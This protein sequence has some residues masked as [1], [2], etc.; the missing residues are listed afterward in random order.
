MRTVYHTFLKERDIAL[1]KFKASESVYVVKII[2]VLDTLC[3]VKIVLDI[4]KNKSN[5]LD[6]VVFNCFIKDLQ[7]LNNSKLEK[8]LKA[9]Y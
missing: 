3:I 9:L 2:E 6:H 1:I 5:K 7:P 8:M 4:S